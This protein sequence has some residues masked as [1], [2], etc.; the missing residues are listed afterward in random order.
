MEL[1]KLKWRIGTVALGFLCNQALAEHPYPEPRPGFSTT[2]RSADGKTTYVNCP[3][4]L[5]PVADN[6]L[7][8]VESNMYD[9]AGDEMLNTLP[10]TPA[11]DFNLHEGP[12]IES[13]IDKTSPTDDLEE[14]FKGVGSA[15]QHG[16]VDQGLI[17]FG[18]DVIE[19][20]PIA[21]V[22]S[23]LPLLHYKGPEKIGTVQPIFDAQGVKVGGNINVHQ[24]WFDGR[25]ESDTSYIDPS[26]VQNVPWT[27]TYTVDVLNGGA[28][29]FSPFVMYFDKP[30]TPTSFV[31]SGAHGAPHVAMDSSFYAMSQGQR[32]TIKVKHAAAKYF[33]LVYTW[34]WRRHPPRV[35]VMENALKTGPGGRRLPEFESMVFGTAPSSSETSKL[36]A[37]SMIGELAPAKRMWQALKD[38]QSAS[39]AE[40]VSLMEDAEMSLNDWSDRRALP[41][42]VTAASNVDVTLFYVN[43]TIYGNTRDFKNWH[44]RGSLFKAKLLNGDHFPHGYMN[45]DFGG[46][47]G[48]EPQY[49]SSGGPAKSFTFGRVHWWPSAGGPNGGIMVPP[50]AAD[51]TPGEHDV[52]I[53]LNFDSPEK[54][55]L[56]QFDPLHHDVAVYSLH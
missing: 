43:N 2:T 27:I 13:E 34:G 19:G 12:V 24:V 56:Y 20:N 11:V 48:W 33:N 37:I 21:R 32:H 50:V 7:T 53:I 38:S 31:D 30:P 46:S 49:L 36:A 29:N 25:V 47:R 16:V 6:E 41:R 23:G 26:L 28:D 42:G 55:K 8:Y 5:R 14:V 1:T 18:L 44:G 3:E 39:P 45:V 35:Q 10:S 4:G 17:Q 54:I 51:A 52:E 22:Y 15:A 9:S 40:V